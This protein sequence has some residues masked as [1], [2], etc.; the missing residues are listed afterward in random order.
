M[1]W[2]AQTNGIRERIGKLME[3]IRIPFLEGMNL[4]SILRFFY[5]AIWEG[6]ISARASSIAYSFFLAIFPG[7]LFFFTLIPY[8]PIPNLQTEV[9]RLLR[10]VLPPQSY[11][12]AYTTIADVLNNKNSGL[13]SFG[14][15]AALLF[16]TNGTSSLLSNFGQTIHRKESVEFWRLYLYSLL[17][18]IIFSAVF[19][20]GII[21]I[22]MTQSVTDFMVGKDWIQQANADLLQNTR[23]M[24]LLGTLL[25][26]VSALYFFSPMRKGQW[27]F[28]SVGA[29]FATALII[30]SSSGFSY[31]VDNF[32]QYNRLYGS[33]GTLM[34]IMLWIYINAFVLII[35]FELNMS[36]AVADRSAMNAENQGLSE[37]E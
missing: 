6:S 4:R 8:F 35:G 26:S 17:L 20:A 34:V 1:S 15:F 28:F 30:A 32:S 33:I 21:S 2:S 36:V 22:V 37:T 12:A 13:L 27:G 31:Y 5:E 24:V 25:L 11:D 9:F 14:F 10:D 19:I 16:A 29:L 23:W 18:T 7:I 3:T